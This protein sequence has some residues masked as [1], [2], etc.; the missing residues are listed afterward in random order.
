V[1]K[2]YGDAAKLDDVV[3]PLFKEGGFPRPKDD[4]V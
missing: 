4:L 2:T 1:N 3:F